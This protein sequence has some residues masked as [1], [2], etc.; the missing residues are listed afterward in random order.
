MT[1]VVQHRHLWWPLLATLSWHSD[2]VMRLIDQQK[3]AI[4]DY[5]PYLESNSSRGFSLF[6]H[7]TLSGLQNFPK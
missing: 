2:A 7:G 5:S 6:F 4:T 1:R 3:L